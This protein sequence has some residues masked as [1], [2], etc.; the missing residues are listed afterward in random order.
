MAERTAL[1]VALEEA[2][3]NDVYRLFADA[4]V[5]GRRAAFEE[6]AK[7][8]DEQARLARTSLAITADERLAMTTV[9]GWLAERYRALAAS[10]SSNG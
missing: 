6:A 8:A 1:E 4:E 2:N 5:K 10:E 9:S 7:E 3:W